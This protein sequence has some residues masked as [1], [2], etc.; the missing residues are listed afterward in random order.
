M[1]RLFYWTNGL[2][3]LY[4]V[5]GGQAR[6]F[7]PS[8]LVRPEQEKT[9]LKGIAIGI[10]LTLVLGV[11]GVYFFI[12]LGFMPANA[13][14]KPGFFES[15]AAHTSLRATLKREAPQGPN[16]VA[17]TDSHLIDG[18]RLY[19]MNCAVCHG[20]SDAKASN[21]AVGLFQ[22]APQLAREGVEDDPDGAPFWKIKHGIRLTGMP[23]FSQTLTDEQIWEITL[24]LK[25]MDSL[26]A[27][28]G[29]VWKA[30]P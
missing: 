30:L 8:A 6:R 17:L 13:D 7:K 10:A 24:F 4:V 1:E 2:V 3:V 28:P 27:A 5:R 29:R 25:H 21:I 14:G 19:S 9:M 26:P 16:P 11:L 20:Y 12:I 23:G 22:P 15:W 18:I